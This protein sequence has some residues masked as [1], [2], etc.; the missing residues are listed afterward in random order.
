MK[1]FK[2]LK[3]YILIGLAIGFLAACTKKNET[4][5]PQSLSVVV[6]T[7]AGG[8]VQGNQDGTGKAASFFDPDDIT[9]DAQGNFYVVD[10]DNA[11]IRKITP[12]GVV[13]TFAG[14]G[15]AGLTNGTGMAASFSLPLGIAI[16]GGG[17]LYVADAVNRVIRKI[18]PGGVVTTFAG[19]GKDGEDDGAAT[20]AT[21]KVPNSIAID[22]GGNLYVGDYGNIRKIT[23]AGVVSTFVSQG[24]APGF[25]STRIVIDAAGNLYAAD[26]NNNLIRKISPAGVMSTFA[27]NGNKGSADGTVTTASF[28]NPLAIALDTQGNLFV[29]DSDHRIRR[30]SA[31]GAVT[32]IAGNGTFGNT[33]GPGTEATFSGPG[34]MIVSGNVL[35][36]ADT[37]NNS[38]REI[39][40]K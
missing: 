18:T 36:L 22:A 24:A 30:I 7:F 37:G 19:S 11:L 2:Q 39:T 9:V 6:T 31:A 38:I 14:N 28:D 32:T 40:F 29:S 15:I 10:T 3:T 13:T 17:N 25:S 1:K 27:G 4:P 26:Y 33:D 34:G 20:V 5:K 8:T 12:A 35:Y 16:D 21:F 23:T